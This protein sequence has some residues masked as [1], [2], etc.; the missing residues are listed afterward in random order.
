MR[1]NGVSYGMP[2]VSE[3]G[4]QMET[5]AR[6][7]DAAEVRAA[8]AALAEHIDDTTRATRRGSGVHARAEPTRE[9]TRAR[10]PRGR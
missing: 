9:D 10:R 3:I 4:V 7:H 2:T 1:G 6:A 8:A 5:A